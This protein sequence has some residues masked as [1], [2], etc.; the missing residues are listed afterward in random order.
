MD[1]DLITK[2][3]P[4]F[5][6]IFH[7]FSLVAAIHAGLTV[8]TSQG[9]VAWTISLIAFPPLA[10]PLYL[11]M[12]RNKFGGYIE[13]LREINQKNHNSLLKLLAP[14]SES[15]TVSPSNKIQSFTNLSDFAPF[16]TN[17]IKLLI[18]GEKTF[19]S[20]FKA[21]KSAKVY[22][23]IQFFIVRNDNLGNKLKQE[24]I[25]KAKQGIKILFLYDEVGSRNLDYFYTNEMQK[26]GIEILPFWTTQGIRNRFQ[27]NFRNH[28]K[29]VV[30]DGNTAFIGGHNVGDEYL[31]KNPKFG[32]WRDT[33]V[34]IKGPC[35]QSVQAVFIEDWYWSSRKK[36]DIKLKSKPYPAG[37]MSSIV[38]PSGPVSELP[39]CSLLFTQL[40][41]MAKKRIWIASPYFVPNP[42]MI[43]ALQLAA[44][45]GV[46]IS[47]MLPLRPDH[48]LVYFASFSFLDQL[49]LPN[50]KFFRYKA[51]FMHQKVVL[52]DNDLALIGT[53]NADNRSFYLNFEIGILV[54]NADFAKD[55]EKMLELDFKNCQESGIED[56]ENKPWIFKLCV[57]LSHLFAP[58]I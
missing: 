32:N 42:A 7:F 17:D 20:I 9:A 26:Q 50:I 5:Y 55:V 34:R 31:G 6:M 37:N 40:I 16:G 12:G 10:L 30:I 35:V 3:L 29:I 27:I 15:K 33:H 54:Q 39:I 18:N 36:P 47:I 22:I 25:N 51:G 4:I 38:I 52:I 43:T 23:L 45:R 48:L 2:I 57:R 8:R 49:S 11:V 44:L 28:R 24:L 21:I 1:Y 46:Q 56:Y 41:N 13:N 19:N 14:I 53:A 58:I